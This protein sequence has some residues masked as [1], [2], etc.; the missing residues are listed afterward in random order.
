M[1]SPA[2]A[3]MKKVSSVFENILSLLLSAIS[4]I[5]TFQRI[6]CFI[7][8]CDM[9]E[10]C[11]LCI[12]HRDPGVNQNLQLYEKSLTGTYLPVLAVT[13]TPEHEAMS[14]LSLFSKHEKSKNK[15]NACVDRSMHCEEGPGV[16]ALAEHL[17]CYYAGNKFRQLLVAE[18]SDN[19]LK[20]QR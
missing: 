2:S 20:F 16:V 13:D 3:H 9:Q 5:L 6:T 4:I 19:Q 7:T 8:L 11:K 17:S 10:V 15:I 14:R 1:L 12:F 18:N